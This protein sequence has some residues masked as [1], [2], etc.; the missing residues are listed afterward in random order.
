MEQKGKSY[1][2]NAIMDERFF[3]DKNLDKATTLLHTT[4]YQLRK[5]LEKL[6]YRNGI[7]LLQ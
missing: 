1:F 7:T 5:N 6:G 4:I 3:P 2:Q